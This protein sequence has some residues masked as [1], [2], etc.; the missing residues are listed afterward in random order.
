MTARRV[1]VLLVAA[2]VVIV[3]AAW[4]SS[5]NGSTPESMAGQRVL[6]DLRNAVNSVT[7]IRITKGDGTTTVLQKRE[8][9]WLVAERGYP[10]DSSQVRKLL[11][12]LAE[13]S[14]V[15]EKTSDPKN[16]AQLGVEDVSTAQSTGTQVEL[17]GTPK[18]VKLIVGKSSGLK[19]SYV[20]V[21]DTEPS[22]LASP[23]LNV[24]ADP[25]R[26]I[27]RNAIDLP[28]D[29]VQEVALKPEKGPSYTIKRESKEKEFTFT[30]LPKGKEAPTQMAATGVVGAL[31][32]LT[33]DDVRKAEKAC[34]DAPKNATRA[35]YKTFD[36]LTL[37]VVGRA[38][39]DD[40]FI[41]VDAQ[42]TAQETEEEAKNLTAKLGGWELEIPTYKYN[43]IFRS[44]DD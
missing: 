33:I 5:R 37:T 14:V 3:A 27:D 30:G 25:K 16:Y 11:L 12:D 1:G 42:S 7:E 36:G 10:A 22:L 13:L 35:T 40:R 9:D 17:V 38:D 4:L 8:S 18:P 31:A 44:L 34:T 28:T 6:P 29:R 20:R 43:A 21:A 41:C 24:D 19:A 26:W 2:L 23:Q 39:G 32:S 15:E